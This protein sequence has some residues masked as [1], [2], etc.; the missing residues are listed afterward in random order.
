MRFQG[1]HIIISS[2]SFIWLNCCIFF[3]ING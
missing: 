1:N 2:L 3:F